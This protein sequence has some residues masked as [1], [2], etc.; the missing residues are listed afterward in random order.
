MHVRVRVGRLLLTGHQP[1]ICTRRRMICSPE[2]HS[3][4]GVPSARQR[5]GVSLGLFFSLCFA[6]EAVES[7]A[8]HGLRFRT[9]SHS[10]SVLKLLLSVKNW[11]YAG[12][13]RQKLVRRF[14]SLIEV[15]EV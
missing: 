8:I 3:R 5:E 15:M 9:M 14:V 12:L 1:L 10:P 13:M 2:R 6:E 11:L 7:D 4:G